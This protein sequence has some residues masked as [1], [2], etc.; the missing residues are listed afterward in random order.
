LLETRLH[1]NSKLNAEVKMNDGM[2]IVNG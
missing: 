2:G 1:G